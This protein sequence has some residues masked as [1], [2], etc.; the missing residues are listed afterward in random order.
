MCRALETNHYLRS[1]PNPP[2][3][4]AP[5][6]LEQTT[7]TASIFRLPAVKKCIVTDF[8]VLPCDL[9]CELDGFKLLCT[10]LSHQDRYRDDEDDED[11]TDHP[12]GLTMW[13][14]TLGKGS[15]N[16]EETDFMMTTP[17]DAS[18]TSK[19]DTTMYSVAKL[20][21]SMPTD[22]LND[23]I[24]DNQGSLPI[25]RG[26][27]QKYNH[28]SLLTKYRDSHLYIFP[29]WVLDMINANE[30]MLSLAEDVLGWWAKADWQKGL[31]DK[32][33]LREIFQNPSSPNLQAVDDGAIK[34]RNDQENQEAPATED[35]SEF[36]EDAE[37]DVDDGEPKPPLVI[38][39]IIAY[40]HPSGE[41][42][43]LVRRVDTAPLLLSISLMLAKLPSI[44]EVG[45]TAASPFAHQV[46]I[47]A[48]VDIP[49]QGT[50]SKSN[51]LIGEK[52]KVEMFCSIKDSVI[53]ANCYIGNRVKLVRCVLM[54]GVTVK[55][56]C[57]LTNC[58]I[59][60]NVKI[61]KS[62]IL[63]DCEVQDDQKVEPKSKFSWK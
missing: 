23:I 52:V 13:Y 24:A 55:D 53:G 33:G 35:V 37:Y 60:H 26:L 28:T 38:P 62:S 19:R 48:G 29:Y 21:Q 54:D 51:C 8:V 63:T 9:V 61:G 3:L 6:G 50:I 57:K 20:V 34:P 10:W 17:L 7:G 59:G 25:R 30:H 14:D 22:T 27:V 39:S 43:P 45:E 5:E 4:L 40:V 41:D 2:R 16:G 15:I 32:L 44:E 1:L 42:S 47:A 11:D 31:G 56:D 18:L 58:I 49:T 12:G 36:D 46:K